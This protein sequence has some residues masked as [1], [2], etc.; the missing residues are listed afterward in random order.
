MLNTNTFLFS[1]HD[2]VKIK[3]ISNPF[4][5]LFKFGKRKRRTNFCNQLK[6]SALLTFTKLFEV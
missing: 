5:K 3:N 4:T 2:I 1:K 6:T